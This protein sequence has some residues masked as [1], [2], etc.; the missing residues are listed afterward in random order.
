MRK[1]V[2]GKR[3]DGLNHLDRF[4]SKET[5]WKRLE[6]RHFKISIAVIEGIV[7]HEIRE[8]QSI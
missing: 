1:S 6:H 8:T 5:I 4:L 2:T 7:L 3:E